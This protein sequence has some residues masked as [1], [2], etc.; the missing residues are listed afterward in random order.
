M[1]AYVGRH[2]DARN[3]SQDSDRAMGCQ[4]LEGHSKQECLRC[5]S[6]DARAPSILFTARVEVKPDRLFL[7][8][9]GKR[10]GDS[11]LKE[12]HGDDHDVRRLPG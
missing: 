6:I 3:L 10:V 11:V 1:P 7:S 5:S 4:L 9:E 12:R 2:I 8:R